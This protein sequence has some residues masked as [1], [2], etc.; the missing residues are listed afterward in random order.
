M[1]LEATTQLL[2]KLQASLA[3]TLL[4]SN[5]SVGDLAAM[6]RAAG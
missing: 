6:V 1:A 2:G 4:K 3:E 5:V